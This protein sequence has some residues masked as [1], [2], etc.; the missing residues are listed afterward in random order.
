MSESSNATFRFREF[1]VY[2]DARE[3]RKALKQL[4]KK[5]PKEE[6]FVLRPQLWRAMDSVLLNIAEGSERYSDKDFSHF[7]NTA[8]TS[9]NEVVS[10]LDCARDDG[11][12]TLQ[13]H[14]VAL[15]QCAGVARQL[16]GFIAKV[17][18]DGASS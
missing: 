17:R 11:Y 2:Q 4:S 3:L 5:F 12:I 1:P 16:K 8:L 15:A 14:S 13:E 7:L 6:E 10:C 9:L 18:R